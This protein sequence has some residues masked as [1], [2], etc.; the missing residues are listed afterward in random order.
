MWQIPRQQAVRS[1]SKLIRILSV[2]SHQLNLSFSNLNSGWSVKPSRV[3]ASWDQSDICRRGCCFSWVS[4][5]YWRRK[6]PKVVV[7]EVN[8]VRSSLGWK[9]KV[10]NIGAG[11]KITWGD[12]CSKGCSCCATSTCYVGK[13]VSD[14]SIL[15][16][17]TDIYPFVPVVSNYWMRLLTISRAEKIK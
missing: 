14:D 6:F 11:G 4:F 2:H 7:A 15:P 16:A 13:G 3:S 17:P 12:S 1:C 5:N 10:K 9:T 8:A